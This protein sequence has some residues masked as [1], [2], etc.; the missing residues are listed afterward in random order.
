[1][2]W[3]KLKADE[4]LKALEVEQRSGLTDAEADKRLTESGANE[5]AQEQKASVLQLLLVQ[6]KNPLII[7]LIVG[8]LLSFYIGHTIDAIA[9]LVIVLINITISFMQE[10]NMQKSMDSL[11]DMAAPMA[12]VLRNGNWEKIPARTLVPGDILKLDTGTIVAA[13][14]RLLE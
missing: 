12:T 3:Y 2:I 7:I 11:S 8:A 6:V 14:V 9:I 1:M 4:A 13:D 10:L 5:L